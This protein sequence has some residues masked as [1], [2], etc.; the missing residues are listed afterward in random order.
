[1]LQQSNIMPISS[2]SA[3]QSKSLK[4]SKNKRKKIFTDE[5]YIAL[6][7]TVE[8]NPKYIQIMMRRDEAYF[9]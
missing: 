1:M 2:Q 7:Q 3:R 4:L 9:N 5:E 6:A 8:K